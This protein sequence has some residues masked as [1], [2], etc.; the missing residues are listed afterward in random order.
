MAKLTDAPP[1]AVL[2]SPLGEDSHHLAVTVPVNFDKLHPEMDSC[3]PSA[4][5]HAVYKPPAEGEPSQQNPGH[6]WWSPR[7]LTPARVGE[8]LQVHDPAADPSPQIGGTGFQE[9]LSAVREQLST[10]EPLSI[11]ALTTAVSLLIE[12]LPKWF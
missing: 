1:A 6:L 4:P 3:L 11:E 9:R 5:V 10:G 2:E 7:A 8:L 12:A